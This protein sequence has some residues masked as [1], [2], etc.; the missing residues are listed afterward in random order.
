MLLANK[1]T[2]KKIFFMSAFVSLLFV[3]G[4]VFTHSLQNTA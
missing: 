4:I 3:L 1:A 2:A